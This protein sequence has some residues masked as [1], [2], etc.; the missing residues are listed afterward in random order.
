MATLAGFTHFSKLGLDQVDIAGGGDFCQLIGGFVKGIGDFGDFIFFL[1][2]FGLK[3]GLFPANP[4][5]RAFA[6]KRAQ[7]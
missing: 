6:I 7:S 2:K 4:L 3:P 1:E 5:V